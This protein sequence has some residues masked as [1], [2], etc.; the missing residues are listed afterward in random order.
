MVMSADG[1]SVVGGTEQGIGSAVD[2]RLMRELR[3]NADVV[4]IGASTLRASGASPRLGGD[5]T[6]E[7]LRLKRHKPRFPTAATLSRTA[8]LPLERAFFTAGDFDAVVYLSDDVSALK[9][10]AIIATGR[11]VFGLP[12]GREVPE[13]LLHMRRELG[14]S[15][16]LLEGGPSL[17]AEF[18]AINAIDEF[19]VTLGPVIVGG[20]ETLTPV[21]G[22]R[23]FSRE[24]LKPLVL[25]SAVANETTGEVYVRYRVRR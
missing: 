14:A 17:N 18:F 5:V 16:L 10:E 23:A 4:L 21:E 3:V 2:Q 13:M 24:T 25:V 22:A 12:A 6:L 15:V 8:D 9:R 20:R 1:K 19:F 7:E 11:P